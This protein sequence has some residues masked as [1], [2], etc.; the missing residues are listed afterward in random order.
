MKTRFRGPGRQC[1]SSLLACA[2]AGCATYHPK[3]LPTAPDLAKAPALVVP[4]EQFLLPGLKPHPLPPDGLDAT[5]VV[6]LAVF[7]D[8]DLKA[9]RLKE[10]VARAQMME[11]GLLPDPQFSA[12]YAE[13][14]R[15]YGGALGLSE[16]IQALITRGAA[17][18]AA[19]QAEKQVHLDI[20]WQ[21][22]QVA[23]QARQLFIQEQSDRHLLEVLRSNERLLESQYQKE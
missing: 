9:A 4:A 1:I 10:G 16:D 20:L 14:A 19:S 6:M 21:E 23:A 12:G 8:P 18:A 3:P 17:K 22:W 7:N 13:S 15:N 11:A 2:L 5:T